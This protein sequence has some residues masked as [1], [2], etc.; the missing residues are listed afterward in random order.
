MLEHQNSGDRRAPDAAA[1][2]QAEVAFYLTGRCPGKELESI[3]GQGLRPA[4]LA[5]YR[6]LSV[7]RYD[8]PLLLDRTAGPRDCVRPLSGLIDEALAAAAR[9]AEGDRISQQVL[10]LERLLRVAA[11]GDAPRRLSD[12]WAEVAVTMGAGEDPA[13]QDSLDRARAAVTAD[14]ELVDCDGRLPE[15]LVAHV[16]LAV[17]EEKARR[18]RRE[19]ARLVHRV[20]EILR[21][22]LA[23]SGEGRSAEALEASVGGLDSET[24]DFDALS[25]VLL[26]TANR[27]TLTDGRR[28]RLEQI[29]QALEAYAFDP[30]ALRFHSCSEALDAWRARF[31]MLAGVARAIAMAELEIAGDYREE[32]H[33]VFFEDYGADGLSPDDLALFAD[34]LVC[35]NAATMDAVEQA[36]L[37]EILSAGLPIK[38]LVQTDDLLG[39][40]GPGTASRGFDRSAPHF[41]HMALGLNDVFVLQAA[42]SHLPAC[43]DRLV[44]GMT[45][46]GAALFSIFSGATESAGD[47]PPYLVAAAAVDARAFP[48]FAFDPSA[49]DTWA[50]RFSLDG[51][52]QPEDDWP[53]YELAYEDGE[54]RRVSER[55]AFTFVDFAAID[56]RYAR[57][58]ARIPEIRWET[59]MLPVAEALTRPPE[60]HPEQLPGIL[61][62]DDGDRLQKVL[63]D[64][65]LLREARRC[66]ETWHALQEQGGIH[67][68]HAERLLAEA[69]ARLAEAE[70]GSGAV[71]GE[72]VAEEK[73]LAD[74]EALAG[75]IGEGAEPESGA[76]TVAAAETG[77]VPGEDDP[78]IETP[79]CT[80]CNEC[81]QINDHMFA[82]NENRQA[83]IADPDAGTYAQLVEAAESCQVSIIHPGKPRNPDEPGLDALIE[84]AQPFL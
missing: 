52:P 48:L 72:A 59:D 79:R 36:A 60:D 50:S 42:S 14:G 10:R 47:L 6:D 63:S 21:A 8:Y 78:Y 13:L 32:R 70:T 24:F 16:W 15:R 73:A 38:I 61:M 64:Q 39:E 53:R 3:A 25:D 27:T 65:R 80:T 31:P 20:S 41:A 35:V 26:R 11:A 75:A 18:L 76:E 56:A 19:I 37:M 83:Y 51:N 9:D 44:G 34:G 45:F 66:R 40:G 33:D 5:R 84:R 28:R 58:L 62:V 49:G 82:Y 30:D 17:Q 74:A 54:R 4:L 81:T 29:I 43:K 67:N 7:L 1:V 46:P 23:R 69:R 77:E 68:S 57:H 12:L 71:G 2:R 22:D 55:L